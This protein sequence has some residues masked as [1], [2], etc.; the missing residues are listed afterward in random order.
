MNITDG[1]SINNYTISLDNVR[2]NQT[3]NINKNFH[4]ANFSLELDTNITGSHIINITSCDTS[5]C[6]ETDYVFYKHNRQAEFNVQTIEDNKESNKLILN[7]TD[8]PFTINDID[9]IL[10][11]NSTKLTPTISGSGI[12]TLDASVITPN[13]SGLSEEIEFYWEYNIS[14]TY[15]NTSFTNQTVGDLLLIECG[16]GY[17][18]FSLNISFFNESSPTESVI[19]D[20]FLQTYQVFD[21]SGQAYRSFNFTNTSTA[22][23]TLCIHPN[24]SV[25]TDFQ[26]EYTRDLIQYNYFGLQVN[27]SN[28]TSL[29]TLYTTDGTSQVT[30]TVKDTIDS[31]V[32]DVY[33]TVDKFDVGTNTYKTVE[34][35]KTDINGQAIGRAVLY[36]AWY[37][38]TLKK[39]GV[40][41]LVDG[42]AKLLSD[43]KTFQVNLAGTS[44]FDRYDD[45]RDISFDLFWNNGTKN[46]GLTWD[47]P[48]LK[49]HKICLKVE[50][51]TNRGRTVINGEPSCATTKS[52]TILVNVGG[53]VDN[54]MF[55]ASALAHISGSSTVGIIMGIL[56]KAFQQEWRFYE[57]NKSGVGTFVTFLLVLTLFF[58]GI[59]HPAPAIILGIIG[60]GLM[61]VMGFYYMAWPMYMGLIAIGVVTLYRLNRA[62]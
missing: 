51:I 25:I 47:D 44:W 43:E 10:I 4:I 17:N 22:N 61:R 46:F 32:Q 21:T 7:V 58:I 57:E 3:I 34:L 8:T 48:T 29:L 14:G 16:G 2:F 33:I 38:W 62:K 6:R 35:L 1:I 19:V 27:L 42:P 18:T 53:D 37:R 5:S 12:I 55:I 24:A 54:Q 13:I 30:Y 23:F 39:E 26:L 52:G 40:T 15:F 50:N 56:E 31:P 36:T 59:W 41:L 20:E 45:F 49:L 11:Y 9:A 60:L 28:I